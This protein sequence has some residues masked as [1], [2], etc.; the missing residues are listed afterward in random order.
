MADYRKGFG[1][2]KRLSDNRRSYG[3]TPK[4]QLKLLPKFRKKH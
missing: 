4:L 2:K 3:T 1:A